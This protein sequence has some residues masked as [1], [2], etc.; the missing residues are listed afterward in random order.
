MGF[1]WKVSA[2]YIMPLLRLPLCGMASTCPP[3]FFAYAS[4]Y[5]HSSAG[6]WLS[7]V[8][9][10]T[11]WFTRS[12]VVAEDDRA[13]QVVAAGRG[14]PLEA[15]QRGEHTWLV[16]LLGCRGRVRPGRRRELA[17]VE[18]RLAALHGDDRLDGGFD[19]L[20]WARLGHL[21]PPLALRVGKE[22][23]AAGANLIGDA[24]VLG[25]VGDGDPVER[26]VLLEAHAVVDDDFAARGNPEEIV[27]S[28]RHAEHSRVEGVAGVDVGDAPENAVREGLAHIRG[29]LPAS[30]DLGGFGRDRRPGRFLRRGLRRVRLRR[31]LRAPCT[32]GNH[33]EADG[34]DACE[35]GLMRS[36]AFLVS[37][38]FI[39]CSS[40]R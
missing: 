40:L 18:D 4:M 31:L 36:R 38:L 34:R 9:K 37:V 5:F 8:E 1:P 6:S 20:L 12:R 14:R 26:P 33:A 39:L 32:H 13:V 16:P 2:E 29:E 27:G 35:D 23:G 10:G 24:H 7:N 11:I 15:V 17:G 3:V 21:V 28:R 19:A 30:D 25:M 22:F